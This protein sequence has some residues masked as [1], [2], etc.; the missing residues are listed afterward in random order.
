MATALKYIV[1]IFGVTCIGIALTHIAI[2]P[3]AIPGSVPVNAT[4]DSEDRFYATLFLGFG[5]ALVWCSQNLRERGGVFKVLLL[6]LFLG[7]IARIIS[8]MQVGMPNELFVFLGALELIFPP[9]LWFWW[10]RVS[11]DIAPLQ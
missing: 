3:S 9:V 7:G 8:A 5:A 2:G 6:V 1:A 11:A 4:M 10:R